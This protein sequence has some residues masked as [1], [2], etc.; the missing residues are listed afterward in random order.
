MTIRNLEY[1]FKPR[2]IAVVGRGKQAGGPDVTVQFNLIEGGFKGPVMPINPD[3][4]SVSGVL[5]YRDIASLPV[6]PD[7][8]IL[9]TSLDE[10]PTLISELGARGTRAVLL[11]SREILQDHRG[12][13]T[14]LL[15]PDLLRSHLDD[16]ESLKQKIL[17]AAKP[18]LLRI[19]G[20]DHL[21]YAV[22]STHLNAS[23]SCT[24]PLAGHIALLCQSA[25]VMR[26]VIDWATSRDIGFSH[27]I[28]VGMRWDVD[29]G[30]LI[31]YLLR[32]SNT[33]AILMYMENTRNRRKFVSAARAAGRVKPVIVLKPR[34]FRAGPVEDA[35]Y[36]AV[37]QRAGILRVNNI[38]Q[39]FSAAETL[40]TAKPV[41]SNRLTLLSNS[42][43]LAL[44]TSDTLL[45]HGGRLAEISEA[46]RTQ[47]A[48]DCRPDYPI[49]NPVDL[50]DMAGPEEYGK[51][52]DLLL[53][54]PGTDGVL[55][56]HAPASVDRSMDSARAVI[57]R[58]KN[59]RLIMTCWVGEAAV[60]PARDLFRTAHI[61]TYEA[62]G[63]A[64]EA[65]MR[66]AQYRRNQEL[67]IET[68]P[69]IP[70]GFT[71]DIE[72]ARRIIQIALTAGRRRL[73]A[74]E[75]SQVLSAYQIRTVPLQ[76][77]STPE[78]ASEIAL[79]L[80]E[81]VALKIL[82]PDIANKS[83]V[84]GV[85]FGLNNPLEVL[86]A[87]TGMLERVHEL[88]PNAVIDG[89]A[90]QPMQSRHNAYELM[91]G[92]RT[93]RRFG[94]V[95]FFGQGGTE[96]EVIDDVAYALPPLNMQLAHDLMS[97]TRLYRQISANRGRP[98]DLD[99]IALTLIKV[100]QM[101]IDLAELVE[102]DINP[103]WV[104][105]DNLLALDANI[106]ITPNGAP[107]TQRL[108]ISP[109]PKEFERR[110]ELPDGRAFLMRPILP[111]DEPELRDL[112]RRIPSEDVRMR[113]F[114][115]M[116]ELPH[117]MAARLT[118]LDYEREMAFIVTTPDSLP[119]KGRIWGVVRCNAD[120]DMEKAEYSILVDR[121]MT[122]LGLGP[123]L[124]RYII[125]YA[126]SRGIREL[127]GEVLRENESMLRLNRALN[128]H[129]SASLDDP[130][131]L[132][133]SLLLN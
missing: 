95:I 80:H 31:D 15:S 102:M 96:A 123:M 101:V 87:A 49:E 132:H 127:Y 77:A 52:L 78:A 88:A 104:R 106:L 107:A 36:D 125:D 65:F 22:P 42:Y 16:G 91:I 110:Y 51:A 128:F 112:V 6:A 72:T 25:A 5:A 94:P 84:G 57:E 9:T 79:E 19:M 17:E 98:V 117:E 75:A 66:L 30:D 90:V 120:P 29:F 38:E 111:E 45:R 81:P 82:S 21:G 34:D 39:L 76:F 103:I 27:V 70:E 28:S 115:P 69:S 44:L 86:V 46:T 99:A 56:I 71:P 14:A 10:A 109:Y 113:F 119:G 1:L 18:Y 114:Q 2:S 105:P 43:S 58:A 33:R 74:Y 40:A 13:R 35:V 7:L 83:E 126:R 129:V 97:R 24:R 50:G 118:Q 32:D 11:L 108:A 20:P 53:Q 60:E 63:E 4:Q 73:N 47:L 55:V 54:E 68:P 61:P 64:V 37:F 67:L 89:F 121:N 124:M 130:G 41:Y 12:T 93:G 3:Q 116:R 85:T 133:V 26:S 48:R 131:V 59:R 100:S 8:A 23:L 92:V 62:P 122:G